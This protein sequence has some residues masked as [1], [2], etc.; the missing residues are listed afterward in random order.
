MENVRI[1]HG[2]SRTVDLC[3]DWSSETDIRPQFAVSY[4]LESEPI[5]MISPEYCA[6]L[7]VYPAGKYQVQ[8]VTLVQ[9]SGKW[10]ESEPKIVDVEASNGG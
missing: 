2:S 6:S 9:D 3:W 5:D 1:L 4:I 10:L 8:I 7:K